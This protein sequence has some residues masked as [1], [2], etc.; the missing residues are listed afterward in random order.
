[1]SSGMSGRTRLLWGKLQMYDGNN[2]Q[3]SVIYFC[4]YFLEVFNCLRVRVEDCGND[5]GLVVYLRKKAGLSR[6]MNE[7]RWG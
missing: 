4:F 2:L 3:S 7:A 6:D 5:L 1:M